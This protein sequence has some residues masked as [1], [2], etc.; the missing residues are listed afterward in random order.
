[1]SEHRPEQPEQPEKPTKTPTRRSRTL[2]WFRTHREQIGIGT[3]GV[4]LTTSV[5]LGISE[6][7]EGGQAEKTQ[8]ELNRVPL[9]L[10]VRP[11]AVQEEFSR[12]VKIL[13]DQLFGAQTA[14]GQ[15]LEAVLSKQDPADIS[16]VFQESITRDSE[17]NVIS[18]VHFDF[19]G[20]DGLLGGELA[21]RQTFTNRS[22]KGSEAPDDAS[23]SVTTI[24]FNIGGQDSGFGIG[25]V[26]PDGSRLS[27]EDMAEAALKLGSH[28]VDG[29]IAD[30]GGTRTRVF[31]NAD[32]KLQIW[33]TGEVQVSNTNR[34]PA[35][36]IPDARQLTATN[37]AEQRAAQLAFTLATDDKANVTEIMG[38]S[39]A[40]G[41][42]GTEVS[43]MPV[44]SPTERFAT[45]DNLYQKAASQD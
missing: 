1:M 22:G 9:A 39:Q 14:D 7:N 25:G 40:L 3:L 33:D 21:V 45:A 12:N 32:S 10:V 26:V 17:G 29:P 31:T 4:A 43:G 38:E 19:G 13:N 36:N 41:G 28:V 34:V 20:D 5:G 37:T 15:E 30:Q 6:M 8:E 2:N 11:S 27:D 35:A 42:A 24:D 44:A 23:I 16:N 18:L